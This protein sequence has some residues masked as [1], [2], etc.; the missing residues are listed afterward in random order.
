MDVNED[1]DLFW[2]AKEGLKAPLPE[3]W[4]PC[5]TAKGEIYYFNFQNG[6][7]IWDHPCDQ[8]YKNL[9]LEEK[10]K[11]LKKGNQTEKI[12][13]AKSTAQ[14]AI[15]LQTKR[16]EKLKAEIAVLPNCII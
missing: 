14:T 2:I 4:K 8:H 1:R 9:F 6:D 13:E 3:P 11:K 5:R 12:V 10:A 16:G 15:K 7:S